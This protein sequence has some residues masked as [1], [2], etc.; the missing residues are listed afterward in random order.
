MQFRRLVCALLFSI[1]LSSGTLRAHA[2]GT[3][4]GRCAGRKWRGHCQRQADGDERGYKN[5]AVRRDR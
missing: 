2:L 3:I 1:I 5:R 4:G